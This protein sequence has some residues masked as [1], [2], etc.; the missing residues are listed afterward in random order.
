MD[1]GADEPR[2]RPRARADPPRDRTDPRR[3]GRA[4]PEP[5]HLQAALPGG[6]DRRLP[7][8]TR[9]GSA[10]STRRSPCCS[11]RR[12]TAFP[13]CPHAGGVGLCE[14]V[15]HLAF[16]DYIAVSGS[17][18]HRVVEWVD[19][20][21]EHFRH[22]AVVVEGR[23]SSPRRRLDTASRCCLCR[24]TSSSSRRAGLGAGRDRDG[25]RMTVSAAKSGAAEARRAGSSARSLP[26][27][28]GCAVS[29]LRA[30]PALIL[31][32][33]IVIAVA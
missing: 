31:L 29:P 20:L 27:A 5:S 26:P 32:L 18:E 7:D 4:R 13:V 14:Y 22:P 9:A 10:A 24:L 33:L 28:P 11:S 16:F 6:G 8:S 19:H 25:R 12:S 1:R 3:D 21:H 15:Q 2:R 23:V 30:G 17:L